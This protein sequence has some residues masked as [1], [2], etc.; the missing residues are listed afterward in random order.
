EAQRESKILGERKRWRGFSVRQDTLQG[1]TA[2]TK[3]GMYLLGSSL[4]AACLGQG[5][6]RAPGLGG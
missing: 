5:A 1:R 6:S 3:C 2:H 4:A